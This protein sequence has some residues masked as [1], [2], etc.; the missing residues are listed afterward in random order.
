MEVLSSLRDY[1]PMDLKAASLAEGTVSP[2]EGSFR[3]K[4]AGIVLKGKKIQRTVEVR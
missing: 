4:N 1:S 3:T 2:N